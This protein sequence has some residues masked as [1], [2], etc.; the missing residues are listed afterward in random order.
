MSA[1]RGSA[2]IDSLSSDGLMSLPL[3]RERDVR[4][5]QIMSSW[6]K[7]ARLDVEM[8]KPE[9][10]RCRE[11]SSVKALKQLREPSM[12]NSVEPI[13]KDNVRRP[14]FRCC[15]F[16]VRNPSIKGPISVMK[17]SCREETWNARSRL[18]SF[19]TSR[20]FNIFL[21]SRKLPV[22]LRSDNNPNVIKPRVLNVLLDTG[23]PKSSV[24]RKDA[25]CIFKDLREV[26]HEA[27]F[28]KKCIGFLHAMSCTLSCCSLRKQGKTSKTA[29]VHMWPGSIKM[30]LRFGDSED[31]VDRKV[32]AEISGNVP[33]Y[34]SRASRFGAEMGKRNSPCP[35][36]SKSSEST[37][38][39]SEGKGDSL[40]S[41]SRKPKTRSRLISLV[42]T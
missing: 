37:N 41:L 5:D 24:K 19:G 16:D 8:W 10:S 9:A 3:L 12:F 30:D 4:F 33:S 17:S 18:S 40:L 29:L 36:S 13:C 20:M 23:C 1:R 42:S 11:S 34:S 2:A 25:R 26:I 14:S 31:K 21:T 22:R 39:R 32:A 6:R 38:L 28:F 27:Q 15:P 35:L 7:L